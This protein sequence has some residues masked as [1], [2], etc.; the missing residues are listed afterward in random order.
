[1]VREAFY[2]IPFGIPVDGNGLPQLPGVSDPSTQEFVIPYIAA[3]MIQRAWRAYRFRDNLNGGIRASWASTRWINR[4]AERNRQRRAAEEH[5]ARQQRRRN[6]RAARR[7]N[8]RIRP[9]RRY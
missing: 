1:M 5:L 7:L 6:Y 4:I 3:Q 8:R 9:E 2:R